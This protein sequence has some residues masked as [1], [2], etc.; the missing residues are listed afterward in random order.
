MAGHLRVKT[1][2]DTATRPVSDTRKTLLKESS[3][4]EQLA[5]RSVWLVEI[6]SVHHLVVEDLLRKTLQDLVLGEN[7]DHHSDA[8][9]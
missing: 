9:A 3:I 7:Q 4:S 1:P 6:M 5:A 8:A 2:G